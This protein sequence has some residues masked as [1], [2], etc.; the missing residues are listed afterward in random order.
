M[1]SPLL[2]FPIVLGLAAAGGLPALPLP[3]LRAPVQGG[4]IAD[5]ED[6][7]EGFGRRK[8]GVGEQAFEQIRTLLIDLRGFGRTSS[9]H[10]LQAARAL[11]DLHGA[12][13]TA[14]RAR[15]AEREAEGWALQDLS[16]REFAALLDQD[17]ARWTAREVLVVE[18]GNTPARRAAAARMLRG[19]HTREVRLALTICIR[20]SVP[21]LAETA[22]RALVGWKDEAVHQLFSGLLARTGPP[23]PPMLLGAA[24]DHFRRVRLTPGNRAVADLEAYV[25]AHVGAEPWR[26]ASRAASVSHAL[27][28]RQA[29]P[30]LIDALEAWGVRV[31]SGGRV[32]RLQYDISRELAARSGLELGLR[33]DRWRTWWGAVES[34]QIDAGPRDPAE[35]FTRAAFFGL[36]PETG[37]VVFV[38]DNSGSMG[39]VFRRE[40]LGTFDAWTRYRESIE[41]M[42]KFLE[43]LGPGAR[44]GVVL[45]NDGTQR[46][47]SGLHPATPGHLKAARAWCLR[48]K[49]QG[50]TQLRHGVQQAMEVGPGGRVDL[51]ALEAD[52]LI[53]LCD[54]QT[55]DGSRWVLPLL[56]RENPLAQVV[57]HC[58]QIGAGGDG[59]LELLAESTGGDFVRVEN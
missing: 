31:R 33:A 47:R 44:F 42:V 15:D 5:I 46:W 20:G 23:A 56:R 30:V 17:V 34:G 9:G 59:T 22:A 7:T 3:G 35:G 43:S 26:S 57:I 1:F 58:V 12:G 2:S 52:T 11:L 21:L 39:Q 36:R 13:L 6:W 41:Q 38:L 32:T 37:R 53:V 4:L 14:A 18:S 25:R 50:G 8:R 48:R 55:S 49:P 45:F 16:A 24:V 10:R 27:P 28:D 29:V 51:D 19:L 40:G 54:G